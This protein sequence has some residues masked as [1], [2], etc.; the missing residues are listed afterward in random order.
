MSFLPSS[1][2]FIGKFNHLTGE[3]QHYLA[4]CAVEPTGSTSASGFG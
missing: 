3:M 4:Q 2:G 1:L